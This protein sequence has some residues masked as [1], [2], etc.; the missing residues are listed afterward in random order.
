MIVP[1]LAANIPLILIDSSSVVKFNPSNQLVLSGTVTLVKAGIA[2]W[3]LN[4]SSVNIAARSLSSAVYALPIGLSTVT[5]TLSANSLAPGVTLA[6]YL[7]STSGNFSSFASVIVRVNAPPTPGMFSVSPLSGQELTDKFTLSAPLW[8]DTDLP[9]QYAF[10]YQSATGALAMQALR[11]AAYTSTILPAGQDTSGYN[12]SC[13]VQVFDSYL[14]Y[15]SAAFTVTVHKA[16][17]K[18]SALLSL[19]KHSYNSSTS[20]NLNS[21]H[22]PF[23]I[24]SMLYP[25]KKLTLL[26]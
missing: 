5:L 26:N 25:V 7:S 3:S 20:H 12:V 10:G 23:K 8:S 17:I 24:S 1:V 6:F 15:S 16:V 11:Q 21:K 13:Q 9:L 4:D 19:G 2:A 14:A 18:A 22:S